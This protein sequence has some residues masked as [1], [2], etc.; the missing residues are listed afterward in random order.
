[1]IQKKDAPSWRTSL[2]MTGEKSN[3][4]PPLGATDMMT[5][6]SSPSHGDI[7]KPSTAISTTTSRAISTDSG[8]SDDLSTKIFQFLA[9]ATPGTLGGVAVGLAAVTYFILGQ[10]GLLLIGAFGGVVLFI[11]WEQRDASVARAVKG[12]RGFDVLARLLEVKMGLN[13]KED[14]DG[15]SGAEEIA[16]TSSSGFDSFQPETRDALNELVE[17]VIRDYVRWWYSPIVPTDKF[18]PLACRK[19]LVSFI[20]NISN[21]LSKKRPADAFLDFLTNSSSI[22][23]VFFS[24]L[25]AAVE[26]LPSDSKMSAADAVYNYL[27]S[28][29]DS[30]LANLLNQRQQAS[31]FRMVAEDLLSFVDRSTYEC[32]PAKV[33]LREILAAVILETTLQK[34]SKPEWINSWIVYLLEA[35]EPDFNHAIDVGMQTGP[36]ADVAFADLDGNVGNIGLA[37]GNRNSFDQE[38]AR[39]KESIAHKKKLSKAEEE[40][41]ALEEVKR[42]NRMIADEDARKSMASFESLESRTSASANR[43]PGGAGSATEASERLASA[44]RRDTDELDI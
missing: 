18:F 14:G 36:G 25:S 29:P 17:A 33:F 37:K 41:D 10:L 39:H 11:Q 23:I 42:L 9:I 22:V 16:L 12:E 5:T 38:R 43:E 13:I 40:L 3:A 6:E 20:T 7:D 21:R 34:C 32:D 15:G 1:M 26:D 30:N 4:T 8:D 31:K 35:G 44:F 27:A 2:E 19:T 28:K 24:E